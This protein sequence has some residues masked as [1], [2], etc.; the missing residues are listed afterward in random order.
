MDFWMFSLVLLAVYGSVTSDVC[1]NGVQEGRHILSPMNGSFLTDDVLAMN[2]A[3]AK[4]DSKFVYL[5]KMT[6][7]IQ[8]C[9]DTISMMMEGSIQV[10]PMM[11]VSRAVGYMEW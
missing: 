10:Q 11:K 4:L 3:S 6:C 8:Q 7:R 5:R 2:N 9:M 1:G